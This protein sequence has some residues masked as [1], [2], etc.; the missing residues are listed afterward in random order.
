MFRGIL[1]CL[2]LG[3]IC[4]AQTFD[5]EVRSLG[6][7]VAARLGGGEVAHLSTVRNLASL[8][9]SE[10]AR[11]RAVFEHALRQSGARTGRPVEVAFTISQNAGGL[12]F[13]AEIER[14][15]ERQVEMVLYTAP[16]APARASHAPLDKR[17][18]W[19]QD[20]P[21][22][23]VG[24]AGD[25]MIVLEPLQMVSYAR[26]AAGWERADARPLEGAAAVRDPRGELR[27]QDDSFT[28][29]LPGAVCRG[30]LKPALDVH[31]ESAA[32]GTEF[33]PARNTLQVEDWPPVSRLPRLTSGR[34]PFT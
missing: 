22:L 30:V 10:T 20:S 19:E 4:G 15:E 13:I 7:A 17:L 31:C 11:A 16:P 34:G 2:L 29:L 18:L 25:A 28:A 8:G 5:E 27:M 21:M 1:L 26:R 24:I 12:L 6:K 23:D 32:A 3:A 14:G 9:S 33:T